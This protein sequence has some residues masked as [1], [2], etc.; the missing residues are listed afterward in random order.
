MGRAVFTTQH[1]MKYDTVDVSDFY[2]NTK[3]GRGIT[4]L[5]DTTKYRVFNSCNLFFFS[6]DTRN[7]LHVSFNHKIVH[8]M[9]ESDHIVHSVFTQ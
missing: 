4:T 1:P 3:A 6:I 9:T 5:F 7:C 8:K 2:D